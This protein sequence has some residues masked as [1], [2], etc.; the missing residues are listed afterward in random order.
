[1]QGVSLDTSFLITL[2]DRNRPNHET[3]KRYWKFFLESQTPIYLST[4]VISEFELK[5]PIDNIILRSCIILPFN[6]ADAVK[7]AQLNFA[8]YKSEAAS[9]D[10]LKDDFKIIAQAEVQGLAFLITDDVE[11]LFKICGQLKATGAV[12]FSAIKLSDGFHDSTGQKLLES[13]L[14][15]AAGSQAEEGQPPKGD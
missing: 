10:A 5:Q 12:S 15:D 14:D 7:S 6:H 8:K 2:A 1:M 9:R 4:I 13:I 11:T 3:A